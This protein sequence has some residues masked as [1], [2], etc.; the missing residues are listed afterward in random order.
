MYPRYT[1]KKYVIDPIGQVTK[2]TK[3]QSTFAP[4]GE[5]SV[6]AQKIAMLKEMISEHG[7]VR[8]TNAANRIPK[9][10]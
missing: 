7:I 1:A 9:A 8:M 3:N 6:N 2:N 10:L 5:R 4:T